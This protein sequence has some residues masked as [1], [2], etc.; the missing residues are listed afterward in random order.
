MARMPDI[1]WEQLLPEAERAAVA[2][3]LVHHG[4]G[5]ATLARLYGDCVPPPVPSHFTVRHLATGGAKRVYLVKGLA[6]NGD[7]Y[8]FVLKQFLPIQLAYLPPGATIAGAPSHASGLD[9]Q[10]LARMV[11][12]A[13]RVD[14]FAP[15]LCPRFGGFWE[16]MGEDGRPRRI[17]TEAYLEGHSL[18]GWKA[19]L[20]E[21]FIRGELDFTHYTERR[22]AL[23]RRAIAAY[24]RLWDVLGRQTFT[25]DPSPWNVLFV[26]TPTGCQPSIIDL[27]SIHDGGT[28]LYVFQILEEL[29]G[30]RDEIRVHALCP[31]VLDALGEAEGVRFLQIVRAELEA[32]AEVRLRTGLSSYAASIRSITRF[33]SR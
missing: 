16:W 25:S 21:R 17:M 26:P 14:E 31:G 11:W 23:E 27:H 15:G 29:F 7:P 24:I 1:Y 22:R 32:Q 6:S 20:E 2:A 10:L 9:V 13:Q 18:D 33:L 28:P 5:E 8:R 30:N 3:A 4:L 19:A 12:A